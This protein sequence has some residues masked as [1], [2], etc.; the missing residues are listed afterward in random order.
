MNKEILNEIKLS[1]EH[2]LKSVKELETQTLPIGEA[3]NVDE[4]D[5][6]DKD[7]LNARRPFFPAATIFKTEFNK[8]RGDY[9][10]GYA[11]GLV[12]HFTAGWSFKDGKERDGAAA[13]KYMDRKDGASSY[14]VIDHGGEVWQ[15]DHL[16]FTKWGYHAGASELTISGKNETSVHK[17]LVGVEIMCPGLLKKNANGKWETWYGQVIPEGVPEIK[18]RTWTENKGLQKKGTYWAYTEAQE[19]SLVALCLFLKRQAPDIFSFDNVV[20]HDE[21][22]TPNGRKVDPGASLSKTMVE[23]REFLKAEYKRIL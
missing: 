6:I 20:G 12:I 22:A 18:T 1:A 4:P 14:L 16:P 15:P 11:E 2:I 7:E 17:F 23:F 9:R 3:P 19:S 5:R 10:K 21:I 13:L 8:A